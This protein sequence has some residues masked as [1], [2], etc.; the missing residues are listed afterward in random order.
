MNCIPWTYDEIV[1]KHGYF[2]LIY[3]FYYMQYLPCMYGDGILF[4]EGTINQ[5]VILSQIPSAKQ[6]HLMFVIRRVLKGCYGEGSSLEDYLFE[7]KFQILHSG[8][9]HGQ[10]SVP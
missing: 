5:H 2:S 7:K 8:T 1:V 4:P 10:D 6:H 3:T 9:L